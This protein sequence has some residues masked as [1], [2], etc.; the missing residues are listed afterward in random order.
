MPIKDHFEP[1]LMFV[2]YLRAGPVDSRIIGRNNIPQESYPYTGLKS[3]FCSF[4]FWESLFL[5]P[6]LQNQKRYLQR[7][8]K[9]ETLQKQKRPLDGV[10]C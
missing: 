1:V 10:A 3:L 9:K 2:V 8:F 7:W 6:I 5:E 4:P